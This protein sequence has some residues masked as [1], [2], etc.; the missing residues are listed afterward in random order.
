M[1]ASIR[2]CRRS[3]PARTRAFLDALEAEFSES[4]CQEQIAKE[5]LARHARVNRKPT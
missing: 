2:R 3:M 4:R 5:Q 1:L